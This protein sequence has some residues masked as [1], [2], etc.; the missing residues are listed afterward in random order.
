MTE[1]LEL[2]YEDKSSNV[3]N[4]SMSNY[5]TLEIIEKQKASAKIKNQV[6]IQ[7]L[8]NT[9][10]EIKSLGEG[11]ITGKKGQRKESTH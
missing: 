2:S 4:S 11:S 7:N 5:Q 8:N 9:E 6:G 10:T 3:K 1:I